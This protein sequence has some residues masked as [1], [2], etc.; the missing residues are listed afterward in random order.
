MIIQETNS[1]NNEQGKEF[2]MASSISQQLPFF[3]CNNVFLDKNYQKDVSKYIYCKDFGVPPYS[4]D[5]GMQPRRWV[6]KYQIIKQAMAEVEERLHRKAMNDHK[7][8][9]GN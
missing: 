6:I 7:L 9:Q 1:I 2:D 8:K 4:G 5:Y 3:C